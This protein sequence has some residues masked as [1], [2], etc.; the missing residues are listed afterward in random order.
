[1]ADES[2]K[3]AWLAEASG[4]FFTTPHFEGYPAVL[5]RLDDVALPDLERVIIEAWLSRAP[6]RLAR[7][8]LSDPRS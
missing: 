1:V 5:V 6:T 7:E 3:A 2:E 8:F 4:S